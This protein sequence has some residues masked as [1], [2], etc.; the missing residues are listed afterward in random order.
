MADLEVEI[1]SPAGS[2]DILLTSVQ[3]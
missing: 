2:S 1:G 3:G